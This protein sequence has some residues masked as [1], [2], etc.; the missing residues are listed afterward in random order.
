[1]KR[2]AFIVLQMLTLS[3]Q[4]PI[5][6]PYRYVVVGGGGGDNIALRTVSFASASTQNPTGTEPA[7][8][9]TDDILV[10]FVV[11]DSASSSLG[12]PAGWTSI[13]SGLAGAAFRYSLCWIRRTGSA[14]SYVWTSSTGSYYEVHILAY[15]G[16]VNSGSPIEASA[17]GGVTTGTNPDCPSMTTVNANAMAIAVG[18]NWTGSG[19]AGW[20]APSGYTRR[21]NNTV[22]NDAVMAD[23][24]VVAA[25]AENPAAFTGGNGSNTQWQGTIALQ[26]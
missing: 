8:A 23:K 5:L 25:G 4:I 15:S 18:A 12:N 6:N 10:A 26:D 17:D 11:V 14:P 21:S 16:C 24:K 2:L 7:G 3:A 20:S 1:M 9:T 22:G 13:Y 19:G